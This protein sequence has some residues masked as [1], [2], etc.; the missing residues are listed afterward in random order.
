MKA[1]VTGGHGFLGSHIVDRLLQEGIE[2]RAFVSP[3]GK[4]DNLGDV[5]ARAGL[6]VARG[7]ITDPE[8]LSGKFDGCD[9]LYHA[10]A[11]A[12][13]WGPWSNYERVTVNG[14]KNVIEEARRA[15]IGRFVHVSSVAVHEY[16]GFRDAD[17]RTTPLG[18]NLLNYP[19]SKMESEGL[20]TGSGLDYVIVRPG[21]YVFGP[22][23]PNFHKMLGPLDSGK[24]PMVRGGRSIVNPAYVENVAHGFLLAG[25]HPQAAGKVYLVADDG[26]PSWREIFGYLAEQLG[27]PPPGPS[28]PCWLSKT[29]S[30]L[31]DWTWSVFASK[32]EP[33]LTKYRGMVMC[34]DVHFSTAAAREELG[35]EPLVDWR[36]G[37]RRLVVS[38]GR[39]PKSS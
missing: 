13:D 36:E 10:A 7:D 38:L 30:N 6:E 1:L 27:A 24:F 39:E 29:T 3:W 17:P 16:S 23:D 9:L 12:R 18:Q 25:T 5:E 21:L 4:L 34:N 37:I 26:A 14:I 22:R 28:L 35:Y 15:K 11:L 19:R 32:S 33:P 2:V 20:V 31:V 8:S